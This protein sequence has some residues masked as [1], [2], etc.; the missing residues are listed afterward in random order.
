MALTWMDKIISNTE[1]RVFSLLLCTVYICVQN[2][3][4][5]LHFLISAGSLLKSSVSSFL[6]MLEVCEDMI[7]STELDLKFLI[8]PFRDHKHKR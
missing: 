8:F 5:V 7:S 4:A 6:K 2:S 1:P 3:A